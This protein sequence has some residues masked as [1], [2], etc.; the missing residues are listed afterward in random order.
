MRANEWVAEEPET[1]LLPH[2]RRACESLPLELVDARTAPDG[3]FEIE[4]LWMGQ[5]NR[6]GNVREAIF[7]LVGSM[8]ESATYIGQRRTAPL[9]DVDRVA[10]DGELLFE[11]VTGM[12]A[13]D[14]PFVSHGHTLRFRVGD[15]FAA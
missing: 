2:L 12:I 5:R 4:L 15:V 14:T 10:P 11:V 7:G 1:H 3:T 6:L 8:A 9:S 13:K